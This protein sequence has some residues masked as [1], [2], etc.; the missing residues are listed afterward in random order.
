VLHHTARGTA[1]E[2]LVIR[3][4]PITVTDQLAWPS[5]TFSI[6][7]DVEGGHTDTVDDEL[8]S[9]DAPRAR[10]PVRSR[11]RRAT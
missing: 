8:A 7:G 6:T 4:V 10:H 11:A 1:G 2:P 9:P 5:G 3:I